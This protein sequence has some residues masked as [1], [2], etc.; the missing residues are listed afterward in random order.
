M[1]LKTGIVG[2]PNVGK[3]RRAAAASATSRR[4]SQSTLFN[5]LVENGKAAAANFPFCT[6]EP[7]VGVVPVPDPPTSELSVARR[8][9]ASSCMK[10]H[11]VWSRCPT[12]EAVCGRSLLSIPTSAPA[13]SG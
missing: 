9:A 5:A 10:K 7:N 1:S 13:C 6:I 3:A 2:L 12:S 11:S 8:S 4:S